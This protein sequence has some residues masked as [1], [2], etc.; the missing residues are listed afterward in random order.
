MMGL[1]T[2]SASPDLMHTATDAAGRLERAACPL[3]EG[4]MTRLF[5]RHGY[6][7]SRCIGCRHRSAEIV[8]TSDHVA[9]IYNDEYFYGGGAGY[10]DYGSEAAL[11]RD[12]GRR[13]AEVLARHMPPGR[14]LDVGAAAGFV[15]EGL[16]QQGWS[17]A[18]LEPNASMAASARD[19]L[20]IDVWNVPLERCPASERFDV[21]MMV[22][23]IAHLVRPREALAAAKAVTRPGGFWLI[24]TWD[25]DS[26]M[27]RLFGKR[28]HEYSPPSVLHWFSHDGLRR[29]AAQ[30]G[31]QEVAH[32]RPPKRLNAGHAKS[33]LGYKLRGSKI[34]RLTE[35]AL[36]AVPN[37]WSLPYPS[38]D[39]FWALFQDTK[40]LSQR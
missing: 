38:F 7:I 15:L 33:L 9:R 6:W 31:F 8:P 40:E 30:F 11:L 32:G 18:A 28:W 20:G 3:C 36:R 17:G 29:L 35:T 12:H 16:M 26:W 19:R 14:V 4:P 22:Q 37:D 23:V 34:G 21:V 13:Y 10:S 24:E 27:A 1:S 25:R 5:S 39:L 2:V